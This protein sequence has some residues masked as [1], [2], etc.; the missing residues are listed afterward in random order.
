M[1]SLLMQ[2]IIMGLHRSAGA[3]MTNFLRLCISCFIQSGAN[4]MS[5]RQ[6]QTRALE[7]DSTFATA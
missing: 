1:D 4:K 6:A 5:V 7:G 3:V 2:L